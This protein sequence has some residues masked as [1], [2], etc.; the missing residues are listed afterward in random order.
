VQP[1]V[2]VTREEDLRLVDGVAQGA[3]TRGERHV[4][5]PLRELV[6]GIVTE[7]AGGVLADGGEGEVAEG[8]RAHLVERGA[9]DAH[10]VDE[11]RLEEVEQP[12]DELALREVTGGSE[13]D[14]G[15]GRGHDSTMARPGAPSLPPVPSSGG[16]EPCGAGGSAAARAV[17]TSC[18]RTRNALSSSRFR[19]IQPVTSSL[20]LLAL[21]A[22]HAGTTL[23]TV[24]RPP[25]EIGSTQSFWSGRSVARQ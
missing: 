11:A 20:H 9:D 10:V 6:P 14:D 22:G 3:R 16:V 2:D 15:R 7:L 8:V 24:Y 19:R 25:R 23:S 4:V 18:S 1:L 5:E 21:Q 13:E 12:G 17:R